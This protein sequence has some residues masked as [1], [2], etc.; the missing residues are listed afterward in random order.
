MLSGLGPIFSI[1]LS[2]KN[3]LLMLICRKTPNTLWN[4]AEGDSS[5][6]LLSQPRA[7][8]DQACCQHGLLQPGEA[9]AAGL[10]GAAAPPCSRPLCT[11][12]YSFRAFINF[13][14][15]SSLYQFITGNQP[16]A[17]YNYSV[18]RRILI[19]SYFKILGLVGYFVSFFF[20]FKDNR[21]LNRFE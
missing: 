19:N 8:L 6:H 9:G 7:Q 11:L 16:G 21:L 18:V 14:T 17:N 3:Q 12:C 20:F 15:S 10:L 1:N 5:A 4:S 13:C 2:Q